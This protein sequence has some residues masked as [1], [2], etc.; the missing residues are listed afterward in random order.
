MRK[1]K[2]DNGGNVNKKLKQW[3]KEHIYVMRYEDNFKV[4]TATDNDGM[5]Q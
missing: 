1:N 4:V 2:Y 5:A 3:M